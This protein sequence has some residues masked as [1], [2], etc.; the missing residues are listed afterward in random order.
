MKFKNIYLWQM[1]TFV[2]M[3]TVADN[4]LAAETK[5]RIQISIVWKFTAL[6]ELD[7]S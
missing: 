1:H 5:L 2:I 7:N 3:F 6:V 4:S